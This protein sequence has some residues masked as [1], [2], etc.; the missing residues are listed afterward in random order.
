MSVEE[1]KEKKVDEKKSDS[2]VDR[3]RHSITS[4]VGVMKKQDKYFAKTFVVKLG[5]ND[6]GS[7]IK[8][9]LCYFE[10]L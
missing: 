9:N 2:I 6:F 8:V 10:L 4:S 7:G 1:L 3:P 5:N